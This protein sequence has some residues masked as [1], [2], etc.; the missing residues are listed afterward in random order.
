M[1]YRLTSLS[2]VFLSA[3]SLF[4]KCKISLK[5][6]VSSQNVSL[7]A[8]FVFVVQDRGTYLPQITGLTCVALIANVLFYHY[9]NL[10]KQFCRIS[11]PF[12]ITLQ[13]LPKFL[14]VKFVK[15]KCFAWKKNSSFGLNFSFLLK[16]W[17]HTDRI[18]EWKNIEKRLHQK[19]CHFINLSKVNIIS[20][21]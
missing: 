2:A 20:K 4:H 13:F 1:R 5:V 10:K 9:K 6:Q 7:S 19:L 8:N 15:I 21:T 16:W 12:F 11:K 18:I 14:I 3:D 17:K